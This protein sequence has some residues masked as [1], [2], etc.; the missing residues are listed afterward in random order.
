MKLTRKHALL[1]DKPESCIRDD[2]RNYLHY[3]TAADEDDPVAISGG[4]DCF[5]V[6]RK[7]V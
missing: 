3:Q 1:S 4:R 2:I 5:L 7:Q 6:W